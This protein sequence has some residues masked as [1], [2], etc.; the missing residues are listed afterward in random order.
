M[1]SVA[2]TQIEENDIP[3]IQT[4]LGGKFNAYIDDDDLNKI[5]EFKEDY[6]YGIRA[7]SKDGNK[8]YLV[9]ICGLFDI[10]WIARTGRIVFYMIDKDG[11]S[12]TIQN[13]PTTNRMFAE[14]IDLGFA[15]LNLN[16]L[17]I[18]VYEHN[19]IK[20]ILENYNFKPEGIRRDDLYK[21][22]KYYNCIVCSLFKEER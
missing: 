21:E 5:L 10:D 17:H 9:G 19:N 12:A 20:D 13:Y 4:I 15:E 11:Q 2:L 8:P 3:K 7:T 14:L 22:G 1:L 6:V 16:K 18:K